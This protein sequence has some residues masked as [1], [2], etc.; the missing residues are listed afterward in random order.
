MNTQNHVE[1]LANIE[2]FI[3][4]I[5]EMEKKRYASP[6]T[7]KEALKHRREQL[8]VEMESLHTKAVG[9]GIKEV[10]K[11]PLHD[12]HYR[13]EDKMWNEMIAECIRCT[14]ELLKTSNQSKPEA[15]ADYQHQL[16][17]GRAILRKVGHTEKEIDEAI[18]F[19]FTTKYQKKN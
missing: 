16:T 18:H 4:E 13:P 8:Y 6:A 14:D 9:H 12:G 2:A 19:A 17:A 10:Q 11:L 15:L 7:H 1:Q 3:A 5:N